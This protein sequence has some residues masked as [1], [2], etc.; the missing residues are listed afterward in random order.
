MTKMDWETKLQALNA[1]NACSLMMRKPGDWYVSQNIE[2]KDKSVLKSVCGNGETPEEAVH[3]HWGQAT[4][5]LES[6]EYLIARTY[7]DGEVSKRLAVRWN[8]FMWDHV[9]EKKEAA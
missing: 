5:E 6:H 4:S 7:W 8:G 9:E 1:L 2:I 3:D